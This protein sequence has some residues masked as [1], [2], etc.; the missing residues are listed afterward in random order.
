MLAALTVDELKSRI[1]LIG[2]VPTVAKKVDL[3]ETLLT[4]FS[5]EGLRALWDRLDDTQRSALAET[6]YD[7]SGCF[8]AERFEAK[9]GRSPDFSVTLVDRTTWRHTCTPLDLLLHY[10]RELRGY[11]VPDDIR[12]RL[13]PFVSEP[14][15]TR[16]NP[17]EV[18]PASIDD[19]RLVVRA[20]EQDA[21]TDLAILLRLV[22]QGRIQVSDKTSLPSGVTLRMLA[23]Q[24]ANGDF[25]DPSNGDETVDG[26]V[27]PIKAFAWPLLLQ[28]AGYVQR[29]NGGKLS[30]S[31]AGL[32]ASR[33]PAADSLRTLWRK[34]SS[35]GLLDEF[36][37]IDVIKGQKSRGRVMTAPA[38]RRAV[39]IEALRDCPVGGWIA[40]D[41]FSRYMRAEDH[42][43]AVTHDPWKLYILDPQYGS[44]GY[45]G[46]CDW[47]IL[48]LRY[49]LC[50][51]FEYAAT[52]GVIDVAYVDPVGSRSDFGAMWGTDDLDY[53][54]RYDGLMYFRLTPLGAY[55]LDL[56]PT[57]TPPAAAPSELR[58]S[59][60]PSLQLRIDAGQASQ[61]ELLVLD[62]WAVPADDRHWQLDRQKAL[63]AVE[64][65]LDAAELLEFL[66]ARD[67]QP[68]PQAVEAFVRSIQ[69][70][71]KALKLVGTVLLI[72]CRNAAIAAAIAAHKETTALCV[73][74]GE[75]QLIVRREHEDKFRA[76]VRMLGFGVTK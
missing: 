57:Y 73:Q 37:R 67:E 4:C 42:Y 6:V 44:L 5:D 41:D 70:N 36:S 21:A 17:I 8:D 14:A 53:L 46:S 23:E 3:I 11:C 43:F 13:E 76:L 48:Q 31:P 18:L 29:H 9:Y 38:R 72:E 30:L 52:L 32:K 2:N 65:G 58:F 12:K 55:C 51:L 50:Y 39:I 10:D 16:L 33:A 24:L 27:G 22:D 25:Y 49:L 35:S 19:R 54:S 40:V 59:V 47:S 34:W 7:P 75:R 69:E 1:A 26:E 62:T 60:L 28:A 71:G 64:N 61:H 20:T 63:I 66:R 45:D 74:A 15:P 68:L 56:S